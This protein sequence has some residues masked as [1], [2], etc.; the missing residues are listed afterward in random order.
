MATPALLFPDAVAA[1]IG[2][3]DAALDVPV[4][5]SVPSPR[6]AS[7]ATVQRTGG[8]AATHRITEDAQIT[9]E[10]WAATHPAASDLA[11]LARYHIQTMQDTT[12]ASGVRVYRIRDLTGPADLPDPESEQ[13]RHT[14]TVLIQIRGATHG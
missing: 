9:V 5:H 13:P 3:L 10:A 12:T 6:P 8:T 7:F 2:H 1:V 11:Q 4:S 14:F